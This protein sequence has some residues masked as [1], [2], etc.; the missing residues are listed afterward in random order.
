MENNKDLEKE[1]LSLIDE[2]VS[3]M[4]DLSKKKK[5]KSKDEKDRKDK[6]KDDIEKN[7]KDILNEETRD[8][9]NY[10]Y[11]Q[12]LDRINVL[13]G[14]NSNDLNNKRKSIPSPE[15]E[16]VGSKKVVWTNFDETCKILNRKIE[17]LMKFF[18]IEFGAEGSLNEE[19]QFVIKGRFL[20]KE[21]Q[22]VLTKYIK[23][24]ISCENCNS[25]NTQIRKDQ[26][27]HLTFLHCDD[28]HSHRSVQSIKAGYHAET[29]ADRKAMRE[30]K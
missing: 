26:I 3:K 7:N 27:V 8:L 20:S 30:Q 18:L 4:F 21:F 24:F 9:P 10:T 5:K 11:E 28:C 16:K 19:K 1:N 25:L 12:L 29:K 17:H 6:N 14:R 13:L 22:N 2:D 23:M 15:I